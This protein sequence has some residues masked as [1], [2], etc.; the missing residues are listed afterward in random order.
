MTTPNQPPRPTCRP[1]SRTFDPLA[2]PLGPFAVY[3]DVREP[4][5]D[6]RRRLRLPQ[7]DEALAEPA[8]AEAAA[9]HFPLAMAAEPECAAMFWSGSGA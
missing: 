3:N 2:R 1:R 8:E 9:R 6:G 7:M 5:T 4:P